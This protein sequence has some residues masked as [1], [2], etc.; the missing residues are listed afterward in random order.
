MDGWILAFEVEL[1]AGSN[2]STKT[3][4]EAMSAFVKL[5]KDSLEESQANR[6]SEMVSPLI[7]PT[8]E[9]GIIS[10]V[11]DCIA[12]LLLS[13]VHL[14]TGNILPAK[15]FSAVKKVMLS[16]DEDLCIKA[17]EFISIIFSVHSGKTNRKNQFKGKWKLLYS[18]TLYYSFQRL[19]NN[20]PKMPNAAEKVAEFLPNLISFIKDN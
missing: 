18:D 8:Q 20:N 13:Q 4:V 14:K 1:G 3:A 15:V 6:I 5:C 12:N 19:L 16:L 10:S 7:V 2:Q 11:F 17:V 9:I